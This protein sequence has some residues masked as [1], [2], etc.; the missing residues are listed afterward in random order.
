MHLY[1]NIDIQNIP[2]FVSGDQTEIFVM[3]L[4]DIHNFAVFKKTAEFSEIDINKFWLF[5]NKTSKAV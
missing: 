3:K 2:H 5:S 4:S 1:K